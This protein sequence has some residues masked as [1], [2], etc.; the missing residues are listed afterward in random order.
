M[1][2]LADKTRRLLLRRPGRRFEPAERA[3]LDET[4][5][6]LAAVREG[7]QL[8]LRNASGT[9][10]TLQALVHHTMAVIDWSFLADL[11]LRLQAD[12]R[13]ERLGIQLLAYTHATVALSLAPLLPA[14][15]ISHPTSAHYRDL[16]RP[17]DPAAWLERIEE[18]EKVLVRVR[19]DGCRDVAP[20]L[21]RRTH[22]YFDSSAWLIRSHL[23]RFGA[24]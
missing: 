16:H 20:P 12:I 22:A 13:V 3:L 6:H 23:D 24:P 1:G 19:I 9:P 21:L 8:T 4:L 17:S 18:L 15:E 7:F 14:S 5:E 10:E 2:R 11:G